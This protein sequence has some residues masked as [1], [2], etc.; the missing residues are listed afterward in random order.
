MSE[1]REHSRADAA[2]E[3]ARHL[4]A[5]RGGALFLSSA[6]IALLDS[7]L[8]EGITVPAVVNALHRL[9]DARRRR[10][11]H[12]P[13]TLRAARRH[14]PKR[15]REP[16]VTGSG[17][18][19]I[20]AR[21]AGSIRLKAEDDPRTFGLLRLAD[22]LDEISPHDPVLALE[23]AQAAVRDFFQ[24]AWDNL[25]AWEREARLTTAREELGEIAEV[26]DPEALRDTLEEIA[27]AELRRGYSWLTREV[28]DG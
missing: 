11:S 10:P 6:D 22:E 23:R 24:S 15:M 3:V 2:E 19:S 5:L 7:W 4:V 9:V 1:V 18:P 16:E 14:L 27:R 28:L 8:A 26:L 21:L 17:E 20:V 25:P 12:L 13:M